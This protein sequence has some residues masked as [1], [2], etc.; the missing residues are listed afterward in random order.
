MM[1]GA[2]LLSSVVG[3]PEVRA[4]SDAQ[5]A[6]AIGASGGASAVGSPTAS[7]YAN[8]AHLT[9]GPSASPFELRLLEVRG[10]TGGDLLQFNHYE[11]TFGQ[12]AGTLTDAEEA[13]VLDQWFG[14]ARRSASTYGEV[15]P[16]ALTYRPSD[17]RWAIGAGLRARSV[18][19]VETGRGPL[20][21]FLVGADSNRTVPVDGGLL[22]YNTVDLTGTFSYALE[23]T[24]LS[25]GASLRFI[26]GSN[27]ADGALDSEVTVT[28]SVLIHQFDYTARA[29]GRFSREVYDTFNVFSADP[30]QD[31]YGV[32]GSGVAGVGAGVDIGATYEVRPDLFVSISLTDLGLIRWSGNAQTV[33]PANNEFRFEGVELDLDRLQNEFDGNVGEYFKNAVDSLARAAY[34]DV[35][36][37]RS[38]FSTG[39]PATLHVGSTWSHDSFTIIGGVTAGLNEG[40]GATSSTPAAYAGGEVRLGPV[41]LRAGLRF[42]GAQ[43][44]TL[45]GGIGLHLRSYQFDIGVTATPSTST[46]GSG[47]RYAVAVSLA[48]VRF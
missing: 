32:G 45:S 34:E 20:D 23:S 48:T 3:L 35:E 31:S 44:V 33:T 16:L 2:A 25:V 42:G 7:L 47:A 18:S 10:Y 5:S 40:A 4:Q 24:P 36:R 30:F 27:Y 15:V 38:P 21:L 17:K 26:V 39:L 41:P 37:E 22:G 14:N 13:S 9:V 28:D 43:A 6:W 29:A 8:P 1:I 46:L 19:R 11:R 12:Q